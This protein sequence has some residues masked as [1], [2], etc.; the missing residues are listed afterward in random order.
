MVEN[1][2][3]EFLLS[4]IREKLA[5]AKIQILEECKDSVAAVVERCFSTLASEICEIIREIQVPCLQGTVASID[6]MVEELRKVRFG[7][8]KLNDIECEIVHPYRMGELRSITV[9]YFGELN[10]NEVPNGL[11]YVTYTHLNNRAS[12]YSFR[13]IAHFQNG[14]I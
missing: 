9:K 8:Q 10:E 2:S 1:T 13:G 7:Q 3:H 4:L 11:G 12:T 14:V 5:R 6:P